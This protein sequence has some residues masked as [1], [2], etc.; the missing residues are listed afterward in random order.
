MRRAA[1]VPVVAAVALGALTPSAAGA[2][3]GFWRSSGLR[4][5]DA[6]GV[7]RTGSGGARVSFLLKDTKKGPRT[8]AVR[9]TFTGGHHRSVRVVALPAGARKR[10]RTVRSANARHLYVQE[11]TGIWRKKKFRVK[12][13]GPR[14]RRY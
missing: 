14:R 4:G 9:L 10:W 1:T 3:V 2:D 8:A 7:Y 11:C 12:A 13:C 6:F 5:V